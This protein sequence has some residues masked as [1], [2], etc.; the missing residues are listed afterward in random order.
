MIEP[1]GVLLTVALPTIVA[2]SLYAV[3]KQGA[4]D[5]IE[6]WKRIAAAVGLE[7]VETARVSAFGP[8]TRLIGRAGSLLVELSTRP[9]SKNEMAYCFAVGGL[10]YRSEE[11]VLHREDFGATVAKTLGS[12]E[13]EVGDPAFDDQLYVRGSPVLAQAVFDADTRR[14]TIRL[15]ADESAEVWLSEGVL[16]YESSGDQAMPDWVERQV[17][18]VLEFARKLSRPADLIG[19]LAADASS[20]P[21]PSARLAKLRTLVREFPRLPATL[22]ALRRGLDD[23]DPRVR[24]L[25]AIELNEEGT[26]RLLE[27]ALD[28]E[29]SEDLQA[30]AL[31][32]LGDRLPLDTG[33]EVLSLALRSRRLPV[34]EACLA[35]LGPRGGPDVV[36]ALAKVLAVE[37]GPLAVAAARALGAS[38]EPLGEAPLLGALQR[39]DEGVAAASAEA[40]RYVGSASAVPRLREVEST[41]DD[42]ALRRAAREAIAQIQ[43]R[44]GGA[45]PG[46]LSLA[47]A[48]SGQLSLTEG[49]RGRVSLQGEREDGSD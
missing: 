49:E 25:A 36:D 10:G 4:R 27:L 9:H 31:A 12:R 30:K 18:L 23:T 14:A 35:A 24:L 47:G 40:L 19:R 2:W 44:L 20:D 8:S 37:R 34:A 32:G 6:D 22:E 39:A 42:G 29:S 17:P 15:F 5:Q 3:A 41:T 48:D 26:P 21:L 33:R 7:D 28:D 45:S 16:H 46:Q 13:L 43:A 11:L 1:I 38:G